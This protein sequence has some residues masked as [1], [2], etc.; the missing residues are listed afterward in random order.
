[1]THIQEN[2]PAKEKEKHV[3]NELFHTITTL[4][5]EITAVVQINSSN[6]LNSWSIFYVF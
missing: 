5:T 6:N 3:M 2:S 4:G 1:M